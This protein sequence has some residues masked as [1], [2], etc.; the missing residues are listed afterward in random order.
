M[1]TKRLKVSPTAEPPAPRPSRGRPPTITSERL[2]DVARDVFLECGIRATTQDVAERAGVSEGVIFHRFKS[3]EALFRQAMRFEDEA[4]PEQIIRAL[5]AVDALEIREALI[6]L[7]ST[8]L[9]IGRVA[10]P[11]MMMAWSNPNRGEC[12]AD[13][14]KRAAYQEVLKRVAGFFQARMNRNELR[15][16]DAEI[17]TRAFTGALHHYC[18][19]QLI[20]AERPYVAL[21]EGM[22]V[23]GLVDLLLAGAEPSIDQSD[24]APASHLIRR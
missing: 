12:P 18:L 17:V 4:L 15:R 5:E 6:H 14:A 20:S 24:R 23:R 16:I 9:E 21:P 10:L 7:A 22:F 8:L 19:T 11:L 13:E 1:S 3:K 2:L